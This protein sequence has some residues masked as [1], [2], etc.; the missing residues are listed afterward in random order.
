M[1]ANMGGSFRLIHRHSASGAFQA[2]SPCVSRRFQLR[3]PDFDAAAERE[4]M[5]RASNSLDMK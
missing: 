3:T 5:K 4:R 2:F 1:E